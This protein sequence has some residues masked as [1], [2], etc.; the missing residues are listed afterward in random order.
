MYTYMLWRA[1]TGSLVEPGRE[2]RLDFFQRY[3]SCT[4][5]CANRDRYPGFIRKP[6]SSRVSALDMV[7]SLV[8]FRAVTGIIRLERDKQRDR[9]GN[10]DGDCDTACP[11]R[12]HVYCPGTLPG[13]RSRSDLASGAALHSGDWHQPGSS[14]SPFEIRRSSGLG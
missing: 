6:R 4:R 10:S 12:G 8:R 14:T 13:E 5:S 7:A 2:I 11:W 3:S 1:P 9:G